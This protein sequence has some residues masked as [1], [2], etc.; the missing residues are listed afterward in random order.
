MELMS[1]SCVV[2]DYGKELRESSMETPDTDV[3]TDSE[4]G[5]KRWKNLKNRVVEHVSNLYSVLCQ[6]LFGDVIFFRISTD[7]S[8]FYLVGIE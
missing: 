4:E 2:K 7:L 6:Q 3:F 1:W 8:I 5:E